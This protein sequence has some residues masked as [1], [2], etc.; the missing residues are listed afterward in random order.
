MISA[1]KTS[2]STIRSKTLVVGAIVALLQ[3]IVNGV[4]DQIKTTKT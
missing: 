4:V 1:T 3:T 2:A